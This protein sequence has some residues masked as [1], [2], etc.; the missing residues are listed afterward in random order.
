MPNI[1]DILLKARRD[2]RHLLLENEAESVCTYYGIRLPKS[3]MSKTAKEAGE[4]AKK[5]G[6]PVVLKIVS[7][8][9]LHKTEAGG[10]L[11]G[12]Q[13]SD[14]VK[15]AFGKIIANAKKYKTGTKILGVLV[16]RMVPAGTEVIVGAFRDQQFGT[17]VLFGLGGVFVE[18]FKDVIFGLAPL[19]R[20]NVCSR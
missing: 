5:L 3:Q 10:V 18:I 14:E 12:L 4:S 9:I 15:K 6:F 7:P 2:G 13:D 11:V 16:Q 17:A 8:N 20:S 1:G 19:S